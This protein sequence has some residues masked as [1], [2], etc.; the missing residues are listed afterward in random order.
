MREGENEGWRKEGREG[1]R[2]GTMREVK[3]G[4]DEGEKIKGEYGGKEDKV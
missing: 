1:I 3:R 4:K 2:G